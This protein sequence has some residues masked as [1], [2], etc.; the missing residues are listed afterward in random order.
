LFEHFDDHILELS[1]LLTEL[2]INGGELEDITNML[3]LSKTI[4]ET[5]LDESGS[6]DET[7]LEMWAGELGISIDD[8][9]DWIMRFEG[10]KIVENVREKRASLCAAI[11]EVAFDVRA[12]TSYHIILLSDHV[13]YNCSCELYTTW[14]TISA[15][16]EGVFGIGGSGE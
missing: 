4:Q 14:I 13:A 3:R 1:Q 12:I 7:D 10:R 9:S 11:F 6:V 8:L 5:Q 16:C 2:G 15:S